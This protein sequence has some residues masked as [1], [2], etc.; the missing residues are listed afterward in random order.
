MA[1]PEAVEIPVNYTLPWQGLW[2][3]L[4]NARYYM[5]FYWNSRSEKWYASINKTPTEPIKAFVP[6]LSG[7]ILWRQLRDDSLPPGD[8][9][10]VDSST[11]NINPGRWEFGSGRRVS[12]IYY[13]AVVS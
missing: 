8:L 6:I 2:I 3:N 12:L 1:T 4:E 7:W 9:V 5:V 13:A 11:K 10:V